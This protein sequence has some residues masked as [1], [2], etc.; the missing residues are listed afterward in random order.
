MNWEALGAVAELVSA[1]GVVASLVY[2]GVQIRRSSSALEAATNQAISDSTEY[3][4]I[5][6]AQSPELAGVWAKAM[7]GRSE[8]S[9]VELVQLEFFTR[10]TFRS[11]QNAYF[12]HR[13]GLLSEH[14]W[15][16]YEGLL[17]VF[18]RFPHVHRWWPAERAIYDA[19]FCE[20]VESMLSARPAV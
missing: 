18:A 1:V 6:V 16:S 2:L 3:R 10:A 15:R 7:I 11:I 9:Q 4:L 13:Q 5:A 17:R 12:Q 19:A 20:Y 14:A 8:L